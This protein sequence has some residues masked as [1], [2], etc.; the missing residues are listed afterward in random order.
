MLG[1]V[2]ALA[3]CYI[4]ARRTTRADP[5][6]ALRQEYGQKDK[7]GPELSQNYRVK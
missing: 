3:A 2:I 6:M 7:I 1:P 5:L 4:P